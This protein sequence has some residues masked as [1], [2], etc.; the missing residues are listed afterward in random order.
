MMTPCFVDV[1]DAEAGIDLLSL[2]PSSD[3]TSDQIYIQTLTPDG[4]ADKT[5][6]WNKP[7]KGDFRWIDL[8]EGTAIEEGDVVFAPGAGL[9]VGGVEG[10]TITIP[11]PTL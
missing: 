3:V 8:D 5:Y 11:G 4:L 6:S 9:W 1:A 2:N 7:R 10:A